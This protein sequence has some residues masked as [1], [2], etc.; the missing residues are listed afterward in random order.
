MLST[1]LALVSLAGQ[2]RIFAVSVAACFD[3]V[4]ISQSYSMLF[5]KDEKASHVC[6]PC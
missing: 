3:T 5:C 6:E 4:F 2:V 1:F